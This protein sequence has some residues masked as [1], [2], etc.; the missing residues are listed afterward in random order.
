MTIGSREFVSLTAFIIF[1]VALF[2][3]FFKERANT[4]FNYAKLAARAGIFGAISTILYIVPVFNLKLPF[5]PSFLSLH[6]DEIPAFVAGYAYGPWTAV[7][8]LLVKT[9]IK[10]PMSSTM[11]VGELTDFCL[12][13]SFVVVATII[14]RKKRNFK[15]VFIGFFASLLTQNLAALLLN[16]YVMLPFYIAVMGYDQSQLLALCQMANASVSDLGWSYG[17]YCVLPLNLIKDGAV[18]F[19]TFFIYRTLHKALRFEEVRQ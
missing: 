16:I 3:V 6:F 7:A 2:A 11:G 19:L 8:V 15:G 12:S 13:L 4:S 18:L 9:L 5:L 17:F 14:Y 10:L 1:S